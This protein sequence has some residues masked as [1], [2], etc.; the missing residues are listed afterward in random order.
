MKTATVCDE[1]ASH[2]FRRGGSKDI[3]HSSSSSDRDDYRRK[4]HKRKNIK[5]KKRKRQAPLEAAVIF[6]NKQIH[7]IIQDIRFKALCFQYLN[8]YK[9]VMQLEIL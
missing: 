4:K 8:L 2:C 3:S 7:F 1:K 6:V 5:G 9:N